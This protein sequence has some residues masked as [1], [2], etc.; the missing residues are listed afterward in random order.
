[1]QP[2][3]DYIGV[4]VGAIILN[5][6][7]ELFMSQRGQKARNERGC[8]EF[9]GGRVEYGETLQAAIMREIQEE[10]GIRITIERFLATDDHILLDEHQHWVATTYITRFTMGTPQILE[11]EKC[12]AIGWFTLATLPQ[13]LSLIT[14][15]NITA[16]KQYLS[17]S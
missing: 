12:A 16:F 7:D 15:Y 14:Q 9:P 2:G 11:P 3:V 4:S 6:R 10:F 5:E 17:I 13:P 1:M 8:W